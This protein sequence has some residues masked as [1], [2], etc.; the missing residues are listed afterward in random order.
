MG[1]PLFCSVFSR[2]TA[3]SSLHPL[4]FACCES[5]E[6][7]GRKIF[8]GTRPVPWQAAGVAHLNEH[9]WF[10]RLRRVS[11]PRGSPAARVDQGWLEVG[12]TH[13]TMAV[14]GETES[15]S[16]GTQPDKGYP[17]RRC[18][19]VHRAPAGETRPGSFCFRALGHLSGC[20]KKSRGSAFFS[21]VFPHHGQLGRRG[22]EQNANHRCLA[23]LALTSLPTNSVVERCFLSHAFLVGMASSVSFE[24]FAW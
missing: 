10:A 9:F 24:G 6:I 13:G 23:A 5:A 4:F 11:R 1:R 20:L 12:R 18:A 2:F 15:G 3:G 17:G 8:P 19:K 7:T 22:V 14:P 16:A 21:L